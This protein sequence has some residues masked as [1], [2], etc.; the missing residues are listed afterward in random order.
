MWAILKRDA[1]ATI[2]LLCCLGAC[3]V[4]VLGWRVSGGVGRGGVWAVAWLA[5]LA[6]GKRTIRMWVALLLPGRV[7]AQL[8]SCRR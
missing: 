6:R 5:P 4:V 1:A 2:G 8:S 3:G 7:A